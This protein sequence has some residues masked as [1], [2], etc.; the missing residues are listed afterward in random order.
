[1]SM[2]DRSMIMAQVAALG[3][4]C[5]V[6]RADAPTTVAIDHVGIA[7]VDMQRTIHFYRDLL[8]MELVEQD[9]VD[10]QPAYDRI[11][12][13][14]DVKAKGAMLKL[15]SM[16]IE[17]FEFEHP[18]GPEADRNRPVNVPGIYHICFV[19]KD[20]DKDYQRLKAAGVLFHFPPQDFGI[21]K[22][23]YGRD[24]DGNVFELLQWPTPLKPPRDS[25][26]H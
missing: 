13:L 3:L 26:E 25:S 14:K 21:A 9:E 1:V 7:V 17:L 16:Q 4:A 2:L 10:R 24:P 18:R 5:G 15:G 6:V 11:F 8:G 12:G 22:A 20:I 19:V 23:A